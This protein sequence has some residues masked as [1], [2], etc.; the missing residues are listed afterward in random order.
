MSDQPDISRLP[1]AKVLLYS[2]L[3]LIVLLALLEG[4]ARLLEMVRPPLSADYGMGFN[5]D[6]RVF[7]ST[8]DPNPV[9]VTRPQ[10]EISFYRQSFHMP[11]PANTYRIF[12]LGESNVYN[13]RFFLPELAKRLTAT[14]TN[15]RNFEIIDVGGQA[16]GSYRLLR[17]AL[18]IINYEPDLLLVYIGHN[19]MAEMEHEAL[20]APQ[21]MV[22]QQRV[23]H[24]AFMRLLRDLAAKTEI[25]WMLRQNRQV[26]TTHEVSALT[27][28]GYEFS[29][30]EIERRMVEYRRNMGDI[31][32]LCR[33]HGVP[34]IM[35]VMASNLWKPDLAASRIKDLDKIAQMY[36]AGD[37]QGWHTRARCWAFQPTSR[38]PKGRTASSAIWPANTVSILWISR[39]PW[40]SLSRMACPGKRS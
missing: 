3:P 6:S 22:L 18:E 32:A 40:R 5:E 14:D 13:L 23:Y 25:A 34:V 4:G 31:L 7:M 8:G 11:K 29:P 12:F 38:L 33:S 15:G 9:M 26:I 17:V 35:G 19:E 30:S 10:K 24:S 20:T 2:L 1:R 39:R 36:T 16:Y 37:Y 21:H 28:P 27:L